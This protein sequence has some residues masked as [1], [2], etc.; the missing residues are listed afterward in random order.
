MK[1]IIHS[2]LFPL[3]QCKVN[4]LPDSDGKLALLDI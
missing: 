1:D 3:A 2:A 4:D